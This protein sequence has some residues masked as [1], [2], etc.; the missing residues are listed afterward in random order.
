LVNAVEEWLAAFDLLLARPERSLAIAECAL[1]VARD[2][3]SLD[4][5]GRQL[6]DFYKEVLA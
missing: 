1:Q 3:F 2:R 6:E 4:A 5:V